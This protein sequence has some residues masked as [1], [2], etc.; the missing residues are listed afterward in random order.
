MDKKPSRTDNKNMQSV[1]SAFTSE[2][3]DQV[4]KIAQSL[5]VSWKKDNTL[6]TRSFTIGV[7]TIGS[8]DGIAAN[9]GAIGSPGNYR[10]FDE[11]DYLTSLS[12]ER[13][14]QIPQGGFSMALAEANLDNTSGRF[15]PRYMGGSSE[16]FTAILP[17]RP[18]LIN[19]GFNYDGIDNLIP[20]FA[21][22]FNKNPQID[23]RNREVQLNMVD[24][25][26]F[27]AT[28]DVDQTSIY[29]GVTTDVIMENVLINQGMSTSQYDLDPGINVIPFALI[30]KGTKLD[31]LFNKLAQ[32]E[33]GHF[34]TNEEG[35]HLFRN[36]QWGDSDTY[37]RVIY[38]SQVINQEAPTDDHIINVVEIKS[39][40]RQKAINQKLW[41]LSAPVLVPANDTVEIFADFTDSDGAMPVLAVDTPAYAAGGATTSAYA[42]NVAE[43]NSG[44]TNN[45]AIS[46]KSFSQF[47]TAYKMV[48]ENTSSTPTFIT[49]LSLWGRPAKKISELYVRRER[50]ASQT[51]Y[52]E[53]PLLIDDNP[54][55]QN[56]DWA[57][58]L[59][60]LLLGDFSD[61]DNIQ[62][63]TIRSMPSLQLWDLVSWQGRSYR[64]FDI[65][66][67]LDPGQGF[68][69][70]LSLL[71]RSIT[72]FF[73][74]GIST[75]GGSDQIAP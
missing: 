21:G 22:V 59:A 71:K 56:Q 57:E 37:Q 70:D 69:S 6:S 44:A 60:E 67:R 7:S 14:L 54:F 53:R 41:D 34:L 73:R 58:S 10:Y 18:A 65:K 15:T 20:Q 13:G 17:R 25:N 72:S 11:S 16:L 28:R 63:L 43:D 30:D 39:D 36:R 12:W 9:P 51:A 23:M 27:F 32:A 61:I 46:L 55:I 49:A 52:E 31:S 47:V 8:T 66:T 62:R 50:Q 75:V 29:T 38:T 24:Y 4:R 5:F 1:S 35:R 19:A 68:V 45:S 48:F 74:I 40:I 64:I 26:G 3:Q 42:T 33:Y 2:E